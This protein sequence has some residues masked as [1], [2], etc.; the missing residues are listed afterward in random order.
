MAEDCFVGA[1][2]L[3]LDGG[4]NAVFLK[5]GDGTGAAL[6]DLFDPFGDPDCLSIRPG[7]RSIVVLVDPRP[8]TIITGPGMTTSSGV[9]VLTRSGPGGGND[10]VDGN[11]PD[12]AVFNCFQDDILAEYTLV[13]FA[14]VTSSI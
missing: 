8:V 11:G 5:G 7:G 10:F 2:D 3:N 4:D 13:D 1:L 12:V 9:S 6:C 14:L